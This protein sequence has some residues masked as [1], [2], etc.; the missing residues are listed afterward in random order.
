MQGLVWVWHFDGAIRNKQKEKFDGE[1]QKFYDNTVQYNKILWNIK[2]ERKIT[3]YN[4]CKQYTFKINIYYKTTEE[5]SIK[6]NM[7]IIL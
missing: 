5:N 4:T 3:K 2:K 1:L 6:Y 7:Q